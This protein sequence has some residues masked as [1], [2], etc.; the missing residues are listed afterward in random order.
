MRST[1]LNLQAIK[2]CI[3]SFKSRKKKPT[4][5]QNKRLTMILKRS[6]LWC[7]KYKN[8]DAYC[9]IKTQDLSPSDSIF[10]SL[11][12]LRISFISAVLMPK[13]IKTNV[14]KRISFRCMTVIL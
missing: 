11:Q 12:A 5:F 4:R 10:R 2:D 7:E 1:M 6:T 14:L 9:V 13:L 8:G 3:F